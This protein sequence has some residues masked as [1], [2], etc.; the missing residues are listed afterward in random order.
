M[1]L[2]PPG[3]AQE[4]FV[5]MKKVRKKNECFHLKKRGK[6]GRRVSAINYLC[7]IILNVTVYNI[8]IMQFANCY[9]II[10]I[11]YVYVCML[12]FYDFIVPQ[13]NNN[14]NKNCEIKT[15][16]MYFFMHSLDIP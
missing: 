7:N 1:K 12:F 13:Q 2:C 14:L 6:S 5:R 4:L 15:M 8:L 10:I 9:N 11:L 3:L 16:R